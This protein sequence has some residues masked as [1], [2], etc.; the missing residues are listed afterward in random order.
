[1]GAKKG[2][3]LGDAEFSQLLM[4]ASLNFTNEAEAILIYTTYIT[5]SKE[6]Y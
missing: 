4:V 2:K 6:L 5:L 3:V 1:M